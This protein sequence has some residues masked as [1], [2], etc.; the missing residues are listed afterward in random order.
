MLRKQD[1]LSFAG[2]LHDKVF[3][4]NNFADLS[5]VVWV[6]KYQDFVQSFQSLVAFPISN[7]S[8]CPYL[9]IGLCDLIVPCF[10]GVHHICFIK[11]NDS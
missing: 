4:K 1:R 10:V 2:V 7:I 6:K 5:D 9:K 8:Y 3:F 11:S